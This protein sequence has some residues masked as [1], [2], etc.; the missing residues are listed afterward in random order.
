MNNS[1]AKIRSQMLTIIG[2]CLQKGLF[3][4]ASIFVHL[5]YFE[6]SHLTTYTVIF[7]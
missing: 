2:N 6:Q 1:E 3:T 7:P 5:V 4:G